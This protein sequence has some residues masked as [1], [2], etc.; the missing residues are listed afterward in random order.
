MRC[1]VVQNS[2]SSVY[3][4]I[5]LKSWQL[6]I[7]NSDREQTKLQE[8]ITNGAGIFS[9]DLA[10]FY[11][12]KLICVQFRVKSLN[13]WCINLWMLILLFVFLSPYFYI[14]GQVISDKWKICV[15]FQAKIENAWHI[16]WS[17]AFQIERSFEFI[18]IVQVAKKFREIRL[19]TFSDRRSLLLCATKLM[20]VLQQSR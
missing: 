5:P 17:F 6:R 2:S 12:H 13:R 3:L 19:F 9:V 16:D 1:S 7:R 8:W 10:R 20:A 14:F 4:Y 15:R 11:P 18:K